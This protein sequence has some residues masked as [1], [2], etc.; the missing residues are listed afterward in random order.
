MP[1][2]FKNASSAIGITDTDVYQCPAATT[3]VV[4]NLYISNVDGT[5]PINVDVKVYDDSAVAGSPSL[6]TKQIGKTI[7]IPAGSTLDF[8][9]ISLEALDKIQ[10]KAAA[11]NSIEVFANILEIT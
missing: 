5:V 10:V 7:P 2:A 4:F 9:K 6:P 1:N 11:V 8:G 3:A